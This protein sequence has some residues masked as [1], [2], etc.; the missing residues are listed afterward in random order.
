MDFTADGTKALAQLR[1]LGPAARTRRR[2]HE[3]VVRVFSTAGT[4]GMPQDVKLS[5]DGRVFYVADT[6]RQRRVD[7]RCASV[8]RHRLRA[9]GP[10]APTASTRAGTPGSCTYRTAVPA[11][12]PCSASQRARS[13]RTWTIPGGGNPDMGGVSASPRS[14]GC[15]AQRRGLRHLHRHRQA[16]RTHPGR[17]WAARGSASGPSR[18]AT[19][20]GTRGSSV[21]YA[22][23]SALSSSWAIDADQVSG[24]RDDLE[25]RA[26]YGRRDVRCDALEVVL[27]PVAD[28]HECR[29]R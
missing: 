7:R 17:R 10:E 11:R 6:D 9:H 24:A 3:R 29:H 14:S 12:S 19:H 25:S 2:A 18:A 1:V 4:L 15:R 20:S 23:S 13:S 5:P 21:R 8:P 26:R 28:D 16:D 27:V 22:S